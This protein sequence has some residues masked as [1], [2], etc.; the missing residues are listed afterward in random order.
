MSNNNNDNDAIKLI[1]VGDMG[2]G[3]TNLIHVAAGLEFC[4]TLLTTTS[5][6]FIQKTYKKGN[7]EYTINLWDTIGQERYR[8]LTKIFVKE[9][10]IVILVYDITNR[11][12]FQSLSYWKKMIE[13]LLD[14]D[15]ILGVIGNKVDLYISETVKQN[16][17]EE[18][19][20]SI[21]AKFRLT[22]A[23]SNP[24][25]VVNFI[26]EL[27]D[28]YLVKNTNKQKKSKTKLN[29]QNK[30]KKKSKCC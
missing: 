30:D 15:I 3:K 23:K 10:D 2:T 22:S 4:G 28:D 5:C 7:E 1:L 24:S 9:S 13:E 19:A 16:E 27:I 17:G 21:G 14:T 25:D 11:E 6:S 20:K 29:E 8:S 12:S 26:D 18:Y